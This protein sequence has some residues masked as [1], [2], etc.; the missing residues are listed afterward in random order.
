MGGYT[1][2]KKEI[3]EMLRQNQDHIFSQIISSTIVSASIEVF[4]LLRKDTTRDRRM[5]Y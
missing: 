2:A 4:E 5:E 3:I 1:T